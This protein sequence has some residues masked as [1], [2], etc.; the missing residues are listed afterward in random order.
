MNIS[1]TAPKLH[2]PA[3]CFTVYTTCINIA[4]VEEDGDSEGCYK[5]SDSDRVF[6]NRNVDTSDMSPSVSATHRTRQNKG[7]RSPFYV[8]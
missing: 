5:D 8:Y 3:A 7:I 1:L 6:S 2:L 4:S